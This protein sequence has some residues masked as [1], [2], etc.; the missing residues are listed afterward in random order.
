MPR[1]SPALPPELKEKTDRL[2]AILREAGR[3]VIGFS[4]GVDSAALLKA[5][6]LALGPQNALGVTAQ[7][8]SI[9]P[10]EVALCRQI[11]QEHG[12]QL[13]VIEYSELEIPNYAA[14]PVNRCYF[15]K[16][17]LFDRLRAIAA[18]WGGGAVV[19]DGSIADDLGDYR[20]GLQAKAERG[21]RSPLCEAGFTKAAVRA[22]ARAWGLPNHAKPASPCLS[23]RIPYGAPVTR[24]KLQQV[25]EAERVLR[26]L[27]FQPAR[28]RHHGEIARIEVAPETFSRLLERREEI[29][30][31]FREIGF[32]YIT[33][34]L[35]GFRSG[36]LNEP[37]RRAV[38]EASP[39]SGPAAP[40][41][42]TA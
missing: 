35:Q 41:R 36:S 10:E 28:C 12:F 1:E 42:E 17:E 4:G 24:E 18:D 40:P 30:R 27:G 8:E 5:A 29:L 37:L 39:P 26:A 13:R 7:S 16:G 14:N 31:R 38:A 19:A 20:P 34:D 6:T 33:L 9:A 25:A 21:V 2:F 3:V 11:A 22:L 23:S 15:C 32:L